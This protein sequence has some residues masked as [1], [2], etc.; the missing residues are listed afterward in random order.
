M[1]EWESHIEGE[2]VRKTSRVNEKVRERGKVSEKERV[3]VRE[4]GG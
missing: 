2:R 3:R 4:K 1:S